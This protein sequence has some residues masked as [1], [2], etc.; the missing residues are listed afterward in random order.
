MSCGRCVLLVDSD[1][2]ALEHLSA[3]LTAANF[4]VTTARN[5]HEALEKFYPSTT[6]VLIT[7]CHMPRMAG[8]EL[9]HRIRLTHPVLPLILRCP[10]ETPA[11]FETIP[12]PVGRIP[13]TAEAAGLID[14]LHR[15]GLG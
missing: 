13:P 6:D 3:S 10:A 5:G 15:M 11:A 9:C 12:G 2:T 1:R 4:K 14:M 7:A 8:A